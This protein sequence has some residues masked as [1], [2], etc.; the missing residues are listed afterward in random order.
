M[1]RSLFWPHINDVI[2]WF[3]QQTLQPAIKNHTSVFTAWKTNSAPTLDQDYLHA[4]HYA[5]FRWF[6]LKALYYESPT[7]SLVSARSFASVWME[8][9]W[10][11]A[12]IH[13]WDGKGRRKIAQGHRQEEP[14]LAEYHWSFVCSLHAF[15]LKIVQQVTQQTVNR[16]SMSDLKGVDHWK[17][18]NNGSMSNGRIRIWTC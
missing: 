7:N 1:G 2:V 5:C 8:G 6:N 11:S 17:C 13:R 12:K 9:R 10:F 15:T 18:M 3:W 16:R 14:R 4:S